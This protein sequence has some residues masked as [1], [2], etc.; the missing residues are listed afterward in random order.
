MQVQHEKR[1]RK[2]PVR[3]KAQAEAS[4]AA[5]AIKRQEA[6]EES[7]VIQFATQLCTGVTLSN[8]RFD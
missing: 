3:Y 2:A 5:N 7:P 8:Q 6:I 1:V 4:A